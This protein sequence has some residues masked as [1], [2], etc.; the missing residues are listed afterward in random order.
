MSRAEIERAVKK[1]TPQE[2]TKLAGFIARQDKL[3]WDKQIEEDFST[4]GRHAG[5]LEKL[6]AQIDGGEFTPLP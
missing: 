5:A 3:G 4:G 1:L 6:D 2:L